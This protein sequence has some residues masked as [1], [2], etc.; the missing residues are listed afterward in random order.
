MM[1]ALWAEWQNPLLYPLPIVGGIL[2]FLLSAM[3]LLWKPLCLL[4]AIAFALLMAGSPMQR[5][6]F[7]ALAVLT[8]TIPLELIF[9]FLYDPKR[10]PVNALSH[11]ALASVPLTVYCFVVGLSGLL[12]FVHLP[13]WIP[14]LL[15]AAY[16]LIAFWMTEHPVA[17]VSSRRRWRVLGVV[18]GVQVAIFALMLPLDVW[19]QGL[20]AA[21][22][23][24]IPLRIRRYAFPPAPTTRIAVIESLVTATCFCLLLLTARWA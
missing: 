7:S 12:V 22:L 14:F 2:C 15:L 21:F 5:I 24:A 1:F 11:V 10:Y 9:Y 19:A 16:G 3:L 17:D 8:V 18:I 6:V 20:I 23:F 13:A 4:I